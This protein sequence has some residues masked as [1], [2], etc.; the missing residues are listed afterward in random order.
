MVKTRM[1]VTGGSIGSTISTVMKEGS[2]LSFW[3]GLPFAYGREASYT[4][5]KLGAYAP[6]RDMMG[7]GK[8]D[9]PFYLKFLAGAIT[10]GIGSV[11]G[12]PFDVMKTLA[13]TGSG[14]ASLGKLVTDMYRDQGIAGFYRGVEVNIMRACV[15]NATKMGCYDIT[16]GAVVEKTGWKRKDIR[17]SFTAACVA[18]LFMTC[19]VA[20]FDMIRTKLMN[21]PTDKKIYDGFVDCLVKSVKG[22]GVLSLWRG[23]IPIWARFAPQATLQLLTIDALYTVFGFKSI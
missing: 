2:I 21:Q 16:K 17:T 14:K 4:S 6:V 13:Q 1:Q 12:N 10:G 7:A 19:T 3:K 22:E 18:G 20:P 8:P 9:A 23:F 15:L 5:I 11:V